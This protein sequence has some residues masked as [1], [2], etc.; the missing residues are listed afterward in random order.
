[1]DYEDAVRE[2][3]AHQLLAPDGPDGYTFRHALLREAVY[4]DLLPGERTRLHARLASL[5]SAVP[6]AA[7]ELAHHSLA[8][9]DVPGAFD[10]SIR[11]GSEAGMI[12]APTESHRHYDQALAL[13][14]RVEEAEKLA[15]MTRGKLGLKSAL[16]AAASGDVPRAVHLLRGSACCSPTVPRRRDAARP[17]RR[18]SAPPR[19]DQELSSRVGERLAYYMLQIDGSDVPA[20]ALRIARETVDQTPADPPTWYFARAMATYAIAL[21]AI[22]D[23]AAAGEWAKRARAV[24]GSPTPRPSRPT[25]WSR[26]ASSA[27]AKAI[28]TRP[29]ACSPPLSSTPPRPGCLA[30][31]CA[32]PTTSRTSGWSAAS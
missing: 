31:S 15:G 27:A 19:D 6:G 32:P 25:R 3:V 8:S 2:A 18:P 1:M 10:A 4:N 7:A 9:H 24:A 17:G 5:L 12:G 23:N 26:S 28:R 20:E 21:M 13:W 22:G 29:S 11:A 16:A 30:W 14:D